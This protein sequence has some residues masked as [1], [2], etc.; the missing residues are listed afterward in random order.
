MI[1]PALLGVVGVAVLMSLGIWQMQ[2]MHWKD[3]ILAEITG[4][5]GADPVE[6]AAGLTPEADKYRPV[7]VAGRFTGAFV[8]VLAGQVGASPGVR[9]IEAFAVAGQGGRR[10]LID[11][12]FLAEDLRGAARPARDAVVTGNLHW[13]EET[14]S[15]TPPPDPATGLWFVRNVPA[16]AATLGTEPT[17]IVARAPTGD[18]IVPAPVTT[19]GIP[20]NHW[21]Y[22]ITW[23]SL[24][25]VW[26][27]MTGYLLV[28]IGRQTV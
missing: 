17:L 10:V 16:M 11:R 20:N 12:G 1:F 5:I 2:R 21:G 14:D 22:A 13:P 4:M 24:A 26:A 19:S 27:A 23:F 9:V 25:L 8:E 28:R 6:L 7:R 18:G 3:G 15:F